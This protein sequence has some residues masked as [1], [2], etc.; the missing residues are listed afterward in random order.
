MAE[1]WAE[2]MVVTRVGSRD[3]K[4]AIKEVVERAGLRAVNWVG[5]RT[6]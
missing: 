6:S 4:R 3:G 5:S 2:R 1:C